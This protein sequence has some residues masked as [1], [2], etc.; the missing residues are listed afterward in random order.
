M[1]TSGLS[2]ARS[3]LHTPYG[4]ASSSWTLEEGAF[5]LEVLVPPST[6]AEVFLP[7]GSEPIV[8]AAGK[9]RF[10]CAFQEQEAARGAQA[11]DTV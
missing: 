10:S 1:P 2:W 3:E 7:D 9:H 11:F 5:E 8:V 4:L 6:S